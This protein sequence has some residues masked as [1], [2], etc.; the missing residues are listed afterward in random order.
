M[1]NIKAGLKA[2]MEEVIKFY[3]ELADLELRYTGRL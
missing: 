2:W 1:K 3:G